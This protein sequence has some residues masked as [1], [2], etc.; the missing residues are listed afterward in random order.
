MSDLTVILYDGETKGDQAHGENLR[1][2]GERHWD[3][4]AGGSPMIDEWKA[5]APAERV[6]AVRRGEV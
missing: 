3:S 2:I 6:G 4:P 5:P 1:Q